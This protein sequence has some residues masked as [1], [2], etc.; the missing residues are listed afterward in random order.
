M[1]WLWVVQNVNTQETQYYDD[2][3]QERAA[4]HYPREVGVLLSSFAVVEKW[5]V[6]SSALSRTEF[7]H[8]WGTS[9]QQDYATVKIMVFASPGLPL[10]STTPQHRLK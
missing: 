1:R 9:L 2:D 5:W 10:A 3:N 6:G 7:R 8:A 4:T